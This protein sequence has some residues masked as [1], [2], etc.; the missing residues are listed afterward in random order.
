MGSPCLI[1]EAARLVSPCTPS[2]ASLLCPVFAF[3]PSKWCWDKSH[4][5]KLSP[6]WVTCEFPC[7][8]VF[9][10]SLFPKYLSKGN[11]AHEEIRDIAS[12]V[13]R[14]AKRPRF[15]GPLLIRSRC[16]VASSKVTLWMKAQHEGAL[17]PLCIVPQNRRFHIQLDRWPVIP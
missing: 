8:S 6:T 1:R 15:P 12:W 17:T 9:P 13:V 3:H 2:I 5:R 11:F 10:L 4:C 16:P 7:F 14:H